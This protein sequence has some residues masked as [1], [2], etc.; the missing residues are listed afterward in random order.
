MPKDK[1]VPNEVSLKKILMGLDGKNLK[2][3][4]DPN[5][6]RDLDVRSAIM[7]SLL[8]GSVMAQQKDDLPDTE[9]LDCYMLAR[10]ISDEGLKKYSFKSEETTMVKKFAV[11]R[12]PTESYGALLEELEPA[13]F[14]KGKDAAKAD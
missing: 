13:L 3:G 11:L 12:F 10:K 14:Q 7:I 9:K 1:A 6:L 8:Q 5:D 2:I 4:D